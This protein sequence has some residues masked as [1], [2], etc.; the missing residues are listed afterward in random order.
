VQVDRHESP[1]N[2]QPVAGA[3]TVAPEPRSTHKREQQ[4]VPAPL[5]GFPSCVQPP[6]PPPV[7]SL[8]KPEPP[9]FTEHASPQHSPFV[10]QTS[11]FAW[12]E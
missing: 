3:H 2:R 1:V 11:P 4:F 9:S 12:H 7:N 8:Q 5:H 6:P 10:L